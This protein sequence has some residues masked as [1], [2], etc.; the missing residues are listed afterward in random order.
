[1]F[2]RPKDG[3]DP[4]AGDIESYLDGNVPRHAVPEDVEFVDEMP[5][6]AIGETDK[7]RLRQ[8]EG[9]LDEV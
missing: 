5:L 1:M 9:L 2:V 7:Q 6:T 4:G 3:S 8:R